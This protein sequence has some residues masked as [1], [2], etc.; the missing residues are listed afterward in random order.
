MS[1]DK[2]NQVTEHR[3]GKHVDGHELDRR[4]VF[5]GVVVLL[6]TPSIVAG[7]ERLGS[8]RERGVRIR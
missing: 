1:K 4:L 3:G 6:C 2:E 8:G 5:E 7:E